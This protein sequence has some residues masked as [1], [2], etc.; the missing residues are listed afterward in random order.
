[1]S[2]QHTLGDWQ[3]LPE[4]VGRPYIRI[5]GT[6]LGC[7]FKIANVVMPIYGDGC[8]PTDKLIAM[9]QEE[10]RANARLIAASPNLLKALQALVNRLGR[11]AVEEGVIS[12]NDFRQ[13]ESAI[14]KATGR[15][16]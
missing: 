12:Y 3:V 15:P 8:Q 11:N 6:Q 7:R 16:I 4:E 13:A 9:E 2:A 10:T 5:R 1:M 14:A